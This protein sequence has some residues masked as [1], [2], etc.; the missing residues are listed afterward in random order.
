MLQTLIE[1]V[2]V[3]PPKYLHELRMLPSSKLSASEAL[4]VSVLGQYSGVDIILKDRQAEIKLQ[5]VVSS[6]VLRTTLL[7]FVGPELADNTEIHALVTTHANLVRDIAVCLLFVPTFMRRWISPILPPSIR[8]HRLHR[9]LRELLFKSSR[10]VQGEVPASTLLQHF[11]DTSKAVDEEDIV[12]KLLVVSGA[13]VRV[14]TEA[15]NTL[16]D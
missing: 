14:A 12:A 13:A 7:A 16:V 11:I 9:R 3:L 6:L 1:D 15:V 4:V 2:L 8:M 10:T 5:D